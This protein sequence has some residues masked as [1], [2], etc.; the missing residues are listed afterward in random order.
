[1]TAPAVRTPEPQPRLRDV[2]AS[3][4]VA[5]RYRADYRIP[6][7]T[8]PVETVSWFVN[9]HGWVGAVMSQTLGRLPTLNIA[10]DAEYDALVAALNG[11][12]PGSITPREVGA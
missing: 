11:A 3:I 1:M 7:P 6:L 10:K 5:G 12:A 8:C 4:T 2:T 9:G